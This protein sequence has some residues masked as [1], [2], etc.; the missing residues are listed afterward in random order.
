MSATAKE[1]INKLSCYLAALAVAFVINHL[2]NT[3]LGNAYGT[4]IV[5]NDYY[6]NHSS[7]EPFYRQNNVEPGIVLHVREVVL[8]GNELKTTKEGKVLLLLHG[9]SVPGYIS[10]DLDHENCSMMKYL[11]EAGWDTFTMDY[12]GHGL[13]SDPPIM[14]DVS[15]YPESKAPV[16]SDVAIN[17]VGRVV[18]FIFNLRGVKQINVLGWSLG[19]SRTA[20]IFTIRNQTKVNKLV[21]FAPAYKNLGLIEGYRLYA[22]MMD[23][24]RKVS[25]TNI[26]LKGWYAYGS[27]DEIII[28]GVFEKFRSMMLGSDPK[29]GKLGGKIRIPMGRLVDMMRAERQFDASKITVPT[30]VIRGSLDKFGSKDD[31]ELLVQE[32]GSKVKKFVEIPNASHEIPYEKSNIQ[33]FKAV[34]DF[35]EEN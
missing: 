28:P 8:S 35:L 5:R 22:D 7:V 33:F 1:V 19:A 4:E 25:A 11:A 14:D 21:L 9:Y 20:P 3:E 34:K 10:F 6:V 2:A 16:H 29:S 24:T 30:L 23:N 27:N 18:D 13:S 31:S 15:K 32:L 26:L 17:D 12:E